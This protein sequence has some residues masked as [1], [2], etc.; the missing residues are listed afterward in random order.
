M[1]VATKWIFVLGGWVAVNEFVRLQQRHNGRKKLFDL[2]R[3][4]ADSIGKPLLVIGR[5]D[6][7]TKDRTVRDGDTSWAKTGAHPCGDITVDI[8]P[9]DASSCPNYIQA[10][11]SDLSMI[12]TDS[13]GA[14]FSSCTL[15]HIV[16]LPNAYKEMIRVLSPNGEIYSV[17]PQKWSIFAWLFPTHHWVVETIS[18]TGL[19]L[20]PISKESKRIYEKDIS[21]NLTN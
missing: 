5:P 21:S 16:N 1:Q 19:K 6:G 14:I 8:R 15:E 13:V 4:K 9:K 17:L 2:A 11:A 20:I 12:K 3:K 7:W 10:D 18:K